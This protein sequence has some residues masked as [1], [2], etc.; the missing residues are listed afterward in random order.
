[1]LAEKH[2]ERALK[3]NVEFYAAPVLMGVGLTPDLFPA[4]FSLARHAGWTA[5]VLEQAAD[6]RLIRPD[7]NYVGPAERDLPGLT[8]RSARLSRRRR[9]PVHRG[10]ARARTRFAIRSTT[11][12]ASRPAP[13]TSIDE[14][15]YW[16]GTP[17][18]YRPGTVGLTPRISIGQPSSPTTGAA[19]SE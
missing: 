3:T 17:R 2:P 10:V 19:T 11:Y 18:K 7:V 1:M 16:N 13:A 15:A 14:K 8:D 9:A 4:T 6:N 12:P 5:H